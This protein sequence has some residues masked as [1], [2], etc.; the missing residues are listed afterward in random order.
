MCPPSVDRIF[1]RNR[2]SPKWCSSSGRVDRSDASQHAPSYVRVLRVPSRSIQ[3]AE[4]ELLRQSALRIRIDVQATHAYLRIH[5][6]VIISVCGRLV[7]ISRAHV[8]LIGL[9]CSI[10]VHRC[11]GIDSGGGSGIAHLRECW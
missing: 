11:I 3:C 8:L 1:D 4:C 10:V 7:F 2:C 9:R 6:H 5:V